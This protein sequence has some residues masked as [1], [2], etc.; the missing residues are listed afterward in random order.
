MMNNN[1]KNVT[2]EEANKLI[3][4]NKELVILDV[5]SLGEYSGGHIPGSKLIPSNQIAQRISELSEYIDKPI[6][7]YCASG[8]RSPGAVEALVQNNFSQVYHLNRGISSWRYS[9]EM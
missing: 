7:V 9:I 8:G 2:A 1:V 5:R 3:N 4:E 6:L